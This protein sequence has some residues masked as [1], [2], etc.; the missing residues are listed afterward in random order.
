MASISLRPLTAQAPS[1]FALSGL[2]GAKW[3]RHELAG[4]QEWRIPTPNCWHVGGDVTQDAIDSTI[5][6][7]QPPSAVN[8]RLFAF[9]HAWIVEQCL[10][11]CQWE[12][13]DKSKISPLDWRLA[14]S[15]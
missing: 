10:W 5:C 12:R 2:S 6:L 14:L 9:H 13:E 4:R 1:L 3:S 11:D 8:C 15:A 7:L